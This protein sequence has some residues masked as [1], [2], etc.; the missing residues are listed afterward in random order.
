[1]KEN[2]DVYI[3]FVIVEINGNQW[4]ISN[5]FKNI[6]LDENAE[7]TALRGFNNHYCIR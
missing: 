6:P 4:E 5:F 7:W 1:M 3:R 2:E